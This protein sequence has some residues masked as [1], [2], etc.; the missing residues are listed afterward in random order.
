MI[1]CV[2]FVII[3][4]GDNMDYL[5]YILAFV[6]VIAV[7][8]WLYIDK[9]KAP[10][11][12]K[13][14]EEPISIDELF[15][16]AKATVKDYDIFISAPPG[17]KFS[18]SL[19]PHFIYEKIKEEARLVVDKTKSFKDT[20]LEIID[21]KELKDSNV[22]NKAKV[23]RQVFNNIINKEGYVPSKTTIFKLA[24]ALELHIDD[25]TSLLS[26]VGYSFSHNNL[27]DTFVE[28]CLIHKIYDVDTIYEKLK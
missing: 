26:L 4:S 2:Y 3:I 9:H 16:V 15:D 12:K 5:V 11:S 8:T 14:K 13:V 23:S 21:K 10:T 18:A 7:F 22:Y 28:L 17:V 6:F 20:L 27:E 19:D 24:L 1:S 25:T